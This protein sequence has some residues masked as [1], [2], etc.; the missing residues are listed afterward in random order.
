MQPP[1]LDEAFKARD[2][3][4]RKEM[5]RIHDLEA[6]HH[7]DPVRHTQYTRSHMFRDACDQ[8]R[9]AGRL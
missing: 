1:I 9:Q 8:I 2:P 6:E 4:T 3:A 5:L 7:D